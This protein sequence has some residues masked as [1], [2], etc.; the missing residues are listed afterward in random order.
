MR[1]IHVESLTLHEFAG[2]SSAPPYAILSHT[3]GELQQEDSYLDLQSHENHETAQQ[4]SGF[5]KIAYTCLQAKEDGLEYAWVDTCCI[6][7]SSS[8]E[9]SEAINSMY[10]WY[11]YSL[12]HHS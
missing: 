12:P 9:L 4:K 8:Q 10:R 11:V 5:V 2:A 1:L 6:D 7:K 3:W